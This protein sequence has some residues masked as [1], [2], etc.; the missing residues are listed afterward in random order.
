MRSTARK[1]AALAAILLLLY[2]IAFAWN[3][4][5]SFQRIKLNRT[6]FAGCLTAAAMNQ[7][8]DTK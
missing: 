5:R 4:A 2:G 1:L 3:V 6:G 7:N 8:G